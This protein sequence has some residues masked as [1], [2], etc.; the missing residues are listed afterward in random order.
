MELKEML[1]G[2]DYR[3]GVIDSAI[4]R[5]KLITRKQALEKVP[6]KENKRVI[7]AL[8]FN[9]QL[10]SISRILQSAWRVMT[11]DPKMKKIFPEPPMLAWKRPKSLRDQLVKAKIPDQIQRSQSPWYE[12]M[13]QTKL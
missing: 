10:P 4:Q 6:P 11:L 2:R 9:P 7:F 5:A 8:E 13:Q 12:K 1:L 3:P